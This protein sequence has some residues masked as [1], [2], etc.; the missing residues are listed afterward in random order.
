MREEA[1]KLVTD[2]ARDLVPI[3]I[4]IDAWPGRPQKHTRSR[5]PNCAAL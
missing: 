5:L 2:I 3:E 4:M 1:M